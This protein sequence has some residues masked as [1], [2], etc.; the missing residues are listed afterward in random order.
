MPE[1]R[2]PAE[3]KFIDQKTRQLLV[4]WA[5][6]CAQTGTLPEKQFSLDSENIY[7]QHAFKKGWLTKRLPR[8][9]TAGGFSTAAAFLKR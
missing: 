9:L 2:K 5:D 3:L 8:R 7:V 1:E 4:K 6:V